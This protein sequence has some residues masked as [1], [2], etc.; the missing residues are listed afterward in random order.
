MDRAMSD[1]EFASEEEY[2]EGRMKDGRKPVYHSRKLYEG[3]QKLF[4][5]EPAVPPVADEPRS[6]QQLERERM[7][8]E[9][10]M[11]RLARLELCEDYARK[12]IEC[13]FGA[14]NNPAGNGR[15]SGSPAVESALDTSTTTG[16]GAR[17]T[18]TVPNPK[19][20]VPEVGDCPRR[21]D[22]GDAASL[23]GS[24][25]TCTE[26]TNTGT[27]PCGDSPHSSKGTVPEVGDCPRRSDTSEAASLDAS[28]R[29]CP[30]ATNTGTVPCGDSPHL[31]KG[32]VP[33]RNP[34]PL[35]AGLRSC[36]DKPLTPAQMITIGERGTRLLLSI[37]DE[38]AEVEHKLIDLASRCDE[39][40]TFMQDRAHAVIYGL[41]L[42]LDEQ[43]KEVGF[44]SWM[45]FRFPD[46]WL[47]F[48][49]V[50]RR[51]LAANGLIHSKYADVY[52]KLLDETPPVELPGTLQDRIRESRTPNN[53]AQCKSNQG[54]YTMSELKTRLWKEIWGP[55]DRF[56]KGWEDYWEQQM[57]KPRV[58]PR[59]G[60][61]PP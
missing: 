34:R 33:E 43:F 26:P 13:G 41:L 5:R 46:Q 48:C 10:E 16:D 50:L 14:M 57:I 60:P 30:E 8:Y 44:G 32:T 52:R 20:T 35:P 59:A 25:R 45:P 9:V 11:R 27:V 42:H 17:A 58:A 49:G 19:G 55:R 39:R 47:S 61:P 22:T 53:I 2:L 3:A 1:R 6:P 40:E 38:R 15:G 28:T 7:H 21:S 36:A 54:A 31:S 56:D 12:M 29:N 18:G 4:I 37:S 24:T 23:D 51:V